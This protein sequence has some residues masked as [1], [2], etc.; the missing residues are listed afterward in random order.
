MLILSHPTNTSRQSSRLEGIPEY[1]C[2]L[3]IWTRHRRLIT[4]CLKRSTL[5]DGKAVSPAPCSLQTCRS[6]WVMRV[7]E[8]TLGR[9]KL[10]TRW[11]PQSDWARTRRPLMMM[12]MM[13]TASA[14]G[15]Q[16]ELSAGHYYYIHQAT[17][18]HTLSF[19]LTGVLLS[20]VSSGVEGWGGAR[21]RR[22]GCACH[23]RRLMEPGWWSPEPPPSP[24]PPAAP[25]CR[26]CRPYSTSYTCLPHYGESLHTV[27]T[28]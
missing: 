21:Q 25:R 10:Y 17:S 19:H 15:R 9:Y 27:A 26:C 14:A 20:S 7:V 12:K 5:S 6:H 16:Q 8:H 28:T 4:L 3:V 22:G 1:I 24:P 18:N 23:A 11:P 2:L 13:S